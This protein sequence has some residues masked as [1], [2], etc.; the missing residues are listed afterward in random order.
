M[1]QCQEEELMK[2]LSFSI[3]LSFNVFASFRAL[4]IAASGMEAQDTNVA[5][6]SN[7]IAN[8]NTTGFKMGRVEFED[9]HYQT[10]KEAGARSSDSSQ[11]SVGVQIG[12]GTKVSGVKKVFTAGTPTVTSNPFDLM[13]SGE[14]FFGVLSP[15]GNLSFTR[16]GSFTVDHTSTLV[17]RNGY[18]VF[19][20]I[21]FPANLVSVNVSE[22]GDVEAYVS[23]QIEPIKVGQIPVF[24]FSNTGGLKSLGANLFSESTASGIP[25]QLIA[26]ESNA[27]RV[28]QGMLESSNVSIMNEMTS[29]IK[30]QRSY[31][32]NSKVMGIADQ[33]MS[34]AN[35][36]VR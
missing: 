19:P 16:D 33:M 9:L 20:G 15:N 14:G 27:G 8:V 35:N 12:S 5:T 29:L 26:G 22:T 7:N 17:T 32:S 30:A 34:T 23:G 31:E 21:T 2:Y 25:R 24:L 18:R 4:N 1:I 36:L 10:V 11:Y 6:I 3:L 28:M 13:I